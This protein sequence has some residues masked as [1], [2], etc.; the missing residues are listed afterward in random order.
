KSNPSNL[1]SRPLA[2]LRVVH[3]KPWEAEHGSA[4]EKWT[5]IA[6]ELNR[7]QDFDKLKKGT[8]LKNRFDLFLK[9]FQDD[10]ARSKRKS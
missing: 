1:W 9:R 4:M 2:S 5:R 8:N 10:E 3:E 7:R 6:E